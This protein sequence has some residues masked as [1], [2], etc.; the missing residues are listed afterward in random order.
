MNFHA[1]RKLEE[2]ACVYQSCAVY[3][4]TFR[5]SPHCP[6]HAAACFTSSYVYIIL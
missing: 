6:L 2:V 1:A 5:L 4:S 3:D